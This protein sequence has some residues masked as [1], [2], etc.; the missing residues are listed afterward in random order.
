M[1][2]GMQISDGGPVPM[3]NEYPLVIPVMSAAGGVGRS[4]VTA[5]LAAALHQH[6]SDRRGRAVAVFD[7]R[8]RSA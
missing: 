2:G 7:T 1:K 4:T 8:P 5:L 3:D 6:T